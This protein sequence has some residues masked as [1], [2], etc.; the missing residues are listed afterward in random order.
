MA[1]PKR[2]G[3]AVA[4]SQPSSSAPAPAPGAIEVRRVGG[5]GWTSRRISIYAS[6]VYFLLI[7]LQIPLF[8][9][10]CRA[11]TCTTPIQVT[12]SQLVSNEIFPPSVVKALLYPG[13]IGNNLTKS[14][15]FPR[16][17]DLFDIYNLTEAKNAS[18]LVDLQ[19]LEILAG[20]YF[21]VAG[22][23]VGIINPGRMTLFGTLLVIWGLVKDTLFGKPVNSDPTQSAYVYPT[24]MIALV[25][26]FL[27]IT[28]N[29]KKTA[30]SSPSVTVA[31]PLQSSTKSKLK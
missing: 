26:A 24:I 16:W 8:R 7:M 31:K 6:R 15:T 5:G 19:R 20:S 30:R 29:V 23:L 14:M 3:K 13:A 17:N 1:P 28:Y 21:C 12:S 11:G 27:S 9:V 2:R 4:E 18:A 25:C 10:P 22:A